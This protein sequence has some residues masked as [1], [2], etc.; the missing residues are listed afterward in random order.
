MTAPRYIKI[1][2]R[3]KAPKNTRSLFDH[4][5]N[6]TK[7]VRWFTELKDK[8]GRHTDMKK[9]AWGFVLIVSGSVASSPVLA[10]PVDTSSISM[11]DSLCTIDAAGQE[12]LR[13]HTARYVGL[14]DAQL[15]TT[16][17]F[18]AFMNSRK[19]K[20]GT[21]V[22]DQMTAKEAVIFGNLQEQTKIGVLTMILEDKRARDLRVLIDAA[23]LA[24]KIDVDRYTPK[25]EQSE[26]FIL[27]ALLVGARE[28]FPTKPAQADKLLSQTGT[29]NLELALIAQAAKVTKRVLKMPSVDQADDLITG[30]A[31][32]YGK[33]I[34]R[35]KL[36]ADEK[37]A[38]DRSKYLVEQVKAELNLRDDLLFL[39]R[40]EQVS[41]IQRDVRRESQL[42]APGDNNHINE[43]WQRWI[44]QGRITASQEELSRILNFI[45]QKIPTEFAK[46]ADQKAP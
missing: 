29:C 16:K 31:A 26:E 24:E 44:V 10:K 4:G 13:E 35:S 34:D 37:I 40:L 39:A 7:C 30:L 2:A 43:V 19:W 11:S 41:K 23:E 1:R 18:Q 21:P 6:S 46:S 12:A 20:P 25:D 27:G 3:V 45:D 33:P 38:F 15:S 5:L 32:K 28:L 42:E 17:K 22:G 14:L 36:N 9:M 8:L